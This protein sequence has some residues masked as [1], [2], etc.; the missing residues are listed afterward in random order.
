[1]YGDSLYTTEGWGASFVFL[2]PFPHLS[3]YS[4]LLFSPNNSFYGAHHFAA[5]A[6]QYQFLKCHYNQPLPLAEPSIQNNAIRVITEL[7]LHLL[8]PVPVVPSNNRIEASKTFYL[9]AALTA[10]S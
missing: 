5:F 1:M 7:A 10:G 8:F 9:Y 2:S 6:T 4:C 3:N